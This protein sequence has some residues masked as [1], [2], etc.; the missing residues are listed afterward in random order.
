MKAMK[1][2]SI[3]LGLLLATAVQASVEINVET[4]PDE[5]FR[6]MITSLPEGKDGIL[7]DEEIAGLHELHISG[8][9]LPAQITSLKGIEHFTALE[10]LELFNVVSLKELELTQ[11]KKLAVLRLGLASLEKLDLS[12]LPA[13]SFLHLQVV[14]GIRELDLS[15]CTAMEYL[16]C[17][18]SDF[19]RLNI[20]DC[21][22]LKEL[23]CSESKLSSL[24]LSAFPHLKKLYCYNNQL[25]SLGLSAVTEL[26]ELDCSYNQLTSLDL[27]RNAALRGLW[28]NNNS[29][30][31][32]DLSCNTMLIFLSCVC[33]GI[34]DER[35]TSLVNSLPQTTKGGQVFLE[36][37]VHGS[38]SNK[39]TEEQEQIAIGK[40]WTVLR[41]LP[42]I[43]AG[44]GGGGHTLGIDAPQNVHS[45]PSGD[46]YTL[47]GRRLDGLPTNKGI[48][49]QNG[50]KVVVK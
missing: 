1:L 35:M 30:E 8:A 29:I 24:D 45:C 18:Y 41:E 33:N 25:T 50:R 44:G 10:Y 46:Y 31:T 7:T 48:Y 22:A 32:L 14:M 6:S 15:G 49:I 37:R 40:N 43:C 20:Q 3:M 2:C 12:G 5:A 27:S 39:C 21:T 36:D 17:R 13:L 28:C 19:E 9:G 11:N 47:D 23:Y 34:S 4:F 16:D 38:D 42:L 26:E